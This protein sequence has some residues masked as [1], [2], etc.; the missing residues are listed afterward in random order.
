GA[1]A[2][3]GGAGGIADANSGQNAGTGRLA[4]LRRGTGACGRTEGALKRLLCARQQAPGASGSRNR[5]RVAGNGNKAHKSAR[6]PTTSPETLGREK[7]VASRAPS[8]N[9]PSESGKPPK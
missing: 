7:R 2:A 8:R 3:A 4:E 1:G 9:A 5:L 6:S